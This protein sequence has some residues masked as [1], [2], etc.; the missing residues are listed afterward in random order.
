MENEDLELQPITKIH[1]LY[2]KSDWTL[3]FPVDTVNSERQTFV[4]FSF[5]WFNCH[6]IMKKQ[7]FIF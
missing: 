5:Q 4:Q 1:Y 7:L 3:F 2:K 6:L